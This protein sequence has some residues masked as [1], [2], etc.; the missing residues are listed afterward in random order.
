MKILTELYDKKINSKIL[1]IQS[2]IFEYATFAR[3]II[4]QNNFQRKRVRTANSAYSLLKDDLQKG[5]IMPPLVLAFNQKSNNLEFTSEN[6]EKEINKNVDRLLILDGLQRTFTILDLLDEHKNSVEIAK[7]HEIPIIIELYTEVDKSGILYRML[8]LNTGQTRMS[9]RHQI[10]IIY[11]DLKDS[12]ELG[13]KLISETDNRQP[14]NQDEFSFKNFLDGFTS[15]L[16]GGF[17]PIDRADIVDLMKN[18]ER[19]NSGDNSQDLFKTFIDI[20]II[21]KEKFQTNSQAFS[22]AANNYKEEIDN[23]V[24]AAD[25]DTFFARVQVIAG[26]GAAL[27]LLNKKKII[28][29]WD[30][31]QQ[32]V[33]GIHSIEEVSFLDL[34]EKLEYI[35]SHASKI[36]LEQRR[37]FYFLFALLFNEHEESFQNFG[38]AIKEAYDRLNNTSMVLD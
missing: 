10:E 34:F 16:N 17:A 32:I 19:V 28:N 11:S 29:N 27:N 2:N 37:Y 15:F 7:I 1:L 3:T 35:R 26:L 8:T 4:A 14:N 5:C 20:F 38:A 22:D 21:L 13:I 36:G 24:F 31:M 9:T 23:N 12:E 6:I 33:D 25:L 18:I 30:A